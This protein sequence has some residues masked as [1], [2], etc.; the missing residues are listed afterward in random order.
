M[1]YHVSIINLFQPFFSLETPP[2]DMSDYLVRARS[3]IALSLF[4][5]RGLLAMQES[6]HGWANTITIV[7]HPLSVASFGTLDEIAQA[8]PDPLE[9]ER[10]E[11]YQGLLVCLR[12]LGAL[13]SYSF[14][15]QPLFRL[16]TQKCQAMG[17]HLPA[18][19]QITLDY[20]TTEEWTKNAVNLVSSQYIADMRKTATDAENSRMDAIISAWEGM[21]LE[22]R[23]KGKE[24]SQ[25]WVR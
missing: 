13:C 19:V 14:Y 16:L 18:E 12:A 4:E 3:T 20:Y 9:A 2:E 15:A 7:L 10:S 8:Y 17:L 21:G 24:R 11:P 5:L 23:S 25:S 6:R 1:M 22:E